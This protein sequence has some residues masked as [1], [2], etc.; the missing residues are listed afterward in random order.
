MNESGVVLSRTSSDFAYG[1]TRVTYN[2]DV[3]GSGPVDPT[4]ALAT[5]P[6]QGYEAQ[7]GYYLDSETGLYL[8]TFRHYDPLY[9]R[10]LTRDPIGY[11]GGINLFA[12]TTPSTMRTRM[13]YKA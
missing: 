3:T 6:Y 1:Q 7:H 10:W 11:A 5:D 8:C 9:G 4:S 2:P 13:D 12:R